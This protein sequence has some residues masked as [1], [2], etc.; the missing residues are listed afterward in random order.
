MAASPEFDYIIVGGGTSGSLLAGRLS[1]KFKVLL[2]EA[3]EFK[4]EETITKTHH[5]IFLSDLPYHNIYYWSLGEPNSHDNREAK[6]LV[7]KLLGGG[8]MVSQGNYSYP[9]AL[10]YDRW[11]HYVKDDSWSAKKAYPL[12]ASLENF[13]GV[14]G[15]Y[16]TFHHGMGG[17]LTTFQH[18]SCPK[19]SNMLIE[20]AAYSIDQPLSE[21]DY[22]NPSGVVGYSIYGHHLATNPRSSARDFLNLKND[23]L[24]VC[25]KAIV[26]KVTVKEK[27]RGKIEATGVTF[28]DGS[29]CKH[30]VAKKVILC[31][32]MLSPVILQRSGIGN[33]SI[34]TNASVKVKLE[35]DHVGKGIHSHPIIPMCGYND[36]GLPRI[37]DDVRSYAGVILLARDNK[38]DERA[39]R[40]TCSPLPLVKGQRVKFVVLSCTLLNTV[41]QGY[42]YITDKS[43]ISPPQYNFNYLEE[44]E[45][46]ELAIEGYRKLFNLATSMGI[47]PF[48]Q[49]QPAPNE[50]DLDL[51]KE[52]IVGNR[53]QSYEWTGGCKMGTSIKDGVVNRNC[54]VFG[55]TNLYVCDASIIPDNPDGGTLSAS[56]HVAEVLA[57]KLLA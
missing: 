10:F 39:F 35:N 9:S 26:T 46:L 57:R 54:R 15:K 16:D 17:K 13:K 1:R 49:G 23:N 36:A 42:C 40:I 53:I 41:S 56:L 48:F 21:I 14:P 30:A 5:K 38:P 20:A 8:S 55:T 37:K 29:K 45:D 34:L 7:P 18:S 24:T 12:L 51:V 4:E 2:L 25:C 43:I 52:Y 33:S 19:L 47:T 31:G 32:G 28:L 44:K 22:N 27:D 3:G 50:E 11:A 6:L